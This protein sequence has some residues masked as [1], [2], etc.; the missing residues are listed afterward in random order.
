MVE[1]ERSHETRG[2]SLVCREEVKVSIAIA[3]DSATVKPDPQTARTVFTKRGGRRLRNAVSFGEPLKSFSAPLPTTQRGLGN[4]DCSDPYIAV[5][6]FK[7]A[8]QAIAA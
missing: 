1:I 3:P 4:I 6:V 8:K 7:N 5:R 2:R